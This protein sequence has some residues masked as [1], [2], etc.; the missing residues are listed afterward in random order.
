MSLPRPSLRFS[1]LLSSAASLLCLLVLA[2]PAGAQDPPPP[3]D[4]AL[5]STMEWRL[6]GPFRG[7]RSVAVAGVAGQP[8]TYYF[9]G[10][11]G[12]VWK[13][14]DAGV[15]WENV[16]DGFL[17]TAS[18]GALAVAP[19]DPNVVYVG[20]GEHAPRGVTTSHGDGVYRSTDAGRTW[21]H[22]GLVE[23]R[24]MS[25]IIVHPDDPDW[26]YVAAQGAPYGPTPERGIY[27]SRDGGQTWDHLLFV[28][29]TTGASDLSM[30]PSNPRILYAATW[31][32]QRDPWVVRSGGEGS[33]LWKSTDGGDTWTRLTEGLPDL[34][35]KV[36]V[37][38]SGANPDRVY[39]MIEAEPDGGVYRS[40][41]AG[42][43]WTRVNQTRGL[44]SRPW[45]Y[46]EVFA[47]PM[48]E[49]TV[50]VLNAPF[51]KSIDGGRTFQSIRVGHGDTHD[52]WINP[53]DNR[54]M[55]L[56]DDGG[57]EITF[58]GGTSWSSLNNQPTA[59]F[60]RVNADNRTP[61]WVY[62]G[63]QDNSS[64]AIK[65]RDL[66]GG[67]GPA[68]FRPSAG[69]ESAY[70]AFDPDDPRYQYGGCYLGQISERDEATGLTRN[71]QVRPGLPASVP[72]VDLKYRFNWNAPILVSPHDPGTL[73]HAANHL[74]RSTDRG[75][76][77]EE[78]SPDLTKDDPRYQGP[79]GAPITNE[80]AGGEIY[81]TIFSVA[82]SPVD[83]DVI[84]TGS[85]DGL[86]HV[87]RDGAAT[88]T[89]VTPPDLPDELGVNSVEASPH[90]P[91]VAYV[92]FTAYKFNDFTPYAYR[93]DDYGASWTRITDGIPPDHWVRV[94]REDTE[95]RGLLYAGTELGAFVS[96]DDGARWQSL[97]LDLP[98]T[99]ITDLKVHR[100][101][102]VASTQGRAFWILDDLSPLRQVHA[103]HAA[104]AGADA[105]LFR[106]RAVIRQTGGGGFGGGPGPT[107]GRNPP[108]GAVVHFRLKD[109]PTDS[110]EVTL[111][112]LD[113]E[114]TVLR[115]FSTRPGD[116]PDAPD[117]LD[118]EQGMNRHVWD[119]RREE[120]AGVE[121]L[122]VFG[123]LRGARVPPGTYTARL[124]VG[125]AAPL[126]ARFE[127]RDLPQ[128]TTEITA[129]DHS[130]R[131]TLLGEIRTT[132][133]RLHGGV[134]TMGAVRAQVDAAI[135]RTEEH[136]QSA[137]IRE[138][139]TAL[140]D[141]VQAVDSML[142]QRSWT[143][144]QDPTVFRTR[145]NQFF[146]YLMSAVDGTPGAPTQGMTDQFR[147]LSEEW[148]QQESRVEWI[149]GPGVDAF[150][151]LLR[152]LGVQAVEVGRR[153]VS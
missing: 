43:T 10:V 72:A 11:G 5:Y 122:F 15:R 77:W 26:V 46:I 129:S 121:G 104:V 134:T 144:G 95:R 60:Y 69:C 54:N 128:L 12:G 93:T 108:A 55:I 138:A 44:R 118:V 99:P 74:L 80:G 88:W 49:N 112:F 39:A 151:A 141:S 97:Q 145:L 20:M 38:V 111:R 110:T 73:Y 47:D 68:D 116:G 75:H 71:V 9:G 63:Q 139:G 37:S 105:W 76:S 31:D 150:N 24:A 136:P 127:V 70:I 89:N 36:G 64:V 25:R 19:S 106:P 124:T 113:D 33:G 32:H 131:E 147:E 81:G 17:E 100:G 140:V 123:S 152:E 34:M 85:D 13:T 107:Q 109:A 137:R 48:D 58:N 78:I 52:L 94:I 132:L 6:I 82:P 16:S 148:A 42:D 59:Q 143:T 149:L 115:T 61:Y 35:G 135:E 3:V 30:D 90:E 7:G 14:T 27:R 8:D 103:D 2:A 119:L 117:S 79:G 91:G 65:S 87:T 142:V 67:I 133:E 114:E 120:V 1:R 66:D 96:F 23:T 45:Y 18:V 126:T 22:L 84:W 53:A 41:D 4:P 62:G 98:I 28:N 92:A 86:V 21:T 130:A 125:D 40:D 101:D 83:P 146:I 102:L 29:E 153:M 56:A 57:G 51:W 50:Y